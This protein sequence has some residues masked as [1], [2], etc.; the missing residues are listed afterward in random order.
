MT[1]HDDRMTEFERRLEAIGEDVR[2]LKDDVRRHG[3][4]SREITRKLLP[5]RDLDDFVRRVSDDHEHRI[6]TLEEHSGIQ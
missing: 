5:L 4:L 3:R 2:V 6:T 1:G